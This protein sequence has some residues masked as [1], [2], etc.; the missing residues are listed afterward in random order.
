MHVRCRSI[1]YQRHR[2]EVLQNN[3]LMRPKWNSRKKIV[4]TNK[5]N[6]NILAAEANCCG[7]TVGKNG[8][9]SKLEL[10]KDL[11]KCFQIGLHYRRM[12]NQTNTFIHG[13]HEKFC[14]RKNVETETLQRTLLFGM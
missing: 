11:S 5:L 8:N 3:K 10:L 1:S 6:P 2:K 12:T 14:K 4:T 9:K 13:N 7:W